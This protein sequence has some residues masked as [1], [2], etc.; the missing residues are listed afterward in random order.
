M[1]RE[2][3]LIKKTV[4]FAIGNFGSKVL[5]YVMVLVYSNFIR[6]D[7]M[8]YY[9]LILATVALLQ[10][11]IIFQINDGVYRYLIGGENENRQ[12]ILSTGFQFL[13]LTTSA[14]GLCFIALVW[15]YHLEYAGWIGL[16]F[17]SMMFFTYLQ[18]TVRGLG[19]SKV[20][21][22][23]GILNSLIMLICQVIGLMVLGLGVIALLISMIIANVACIVFLFVW[24]KQLRGVLKYGLD[25]VVA[26]KLLRYS[27]PLVPNAISWW[28]VN[29]CDRYIILFYLGMEFNGIYSMANKFPTILTTITSIF[30]L[31]WQES[32]IK[33]YKTSNRNE[34]FSNIFHRYYVLLFSLCM[35]AIPATKLVIELFVATEY[36]S[37]WLY[38]GFLFMGA[39][40]S[41]LCSFLGL[42][43][44]I[45]KE[46]KRSLATTILAALLNVAINIALIRFIGLQAASFSTFAAYQFLFIIRLKHTKRYFTLAVNWK[47]F[48]LLGGLCLVLI[49]IT[50]LF[51]SLILCIFLC[52]VCIIY[53]VW[54]NCA[55][56]YPL[57]KRLRR[58][59]A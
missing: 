11:L 40:F 29:S 13:C 3:T 36:K 7:D 39:M 37:A 35:C 50:M 45:S 57:I 15:V 27:A 25:K 10:P 51:D 44:Q 4:V 30:Y 52:M 43:Y 26:K 46:T 9:D 19:E 21:A 54:L 47:E 2:K 20:Y 38:T 42:G 55:L 5:A 49:G 17:A 22:F 59:S 31:A 56:I 58:Y 14:A 48:I 1:N 33:E 34:F 8:G 16:Y 18:D 41:A 53:A 28:V 32:A 6:P 12:K 23:C 24:I